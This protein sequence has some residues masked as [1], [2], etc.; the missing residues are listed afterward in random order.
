[1]VEIKDNGFLADELWDLA[2]KAETMNEL[3]KVEMLVRLSNDIERKDAEE[4]ETYLGE[5]AMKLLSETDRK[6]IDDAIEYA[7][8]KDEDAVMN[9]LDKDMKGFLSRTNELAV[10][11]YIKSKLNNGLIKDEDTDPNDKGDLK[12]YKH[13]IGEEIDKT[14]RFYAV[15]MAYEHKL[16]SREDFKRYAE[17]RTKYIN[18]LLEIYLELQ[19]L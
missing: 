2:E 12:E 5:K 17:A 1:M 4:I 7:A 19:T 9:D 18:S 8:E 10:R 11:Y 15:A 14:D 6:I 16:I 3:S 13:K